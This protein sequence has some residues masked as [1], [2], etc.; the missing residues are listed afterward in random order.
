MWKTP[1]NLFAATLRRDP[2]ETSQQNHRQES[3]QESNNKIEDFYLR[4]GQGR[5][6]SGHELIAVGRIKAHTTA[7]SSRHSL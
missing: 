7:S 5:V 3:G 4:Y 6:W 1:L 2:L